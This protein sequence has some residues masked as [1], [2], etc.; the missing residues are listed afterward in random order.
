MFFARLVNGK[1]IVRPEV[2]R[3]QESLVE[4]VTYLVPELLALKRWRGRRRRTVRNTRAY[5]LRTTV[6][7]PYAATRQGPPIH[8]I[9]NVGLGTGIKHLLQMSVTCGLEKAHG[10][11]IVQHSRVR[12]QAGS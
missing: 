7:R 9:R 10:L 2:I 6:S 11:G 3:Q 12:G 8:I 1:E 5:P 4:I